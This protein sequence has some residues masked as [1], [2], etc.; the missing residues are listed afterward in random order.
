MNVYLLNAIIIF[1]YFTAFFVIGQILKNN[2]I[3]DIGWGFGF[4]LVAILNAI[5]FGLKTPGQSIVLIM[6]AVWGLR[7]T[8]HILKR[9]WKKT[10]DFRYVNMRKK[11]G[12]KQMLNAFFKVYMIQGLFMFLIS[13]SISIVFAN[14]IS[15]I[16]FLIGG[17]F[18]WLFGFLFEAVGDYQLKNFIKNKKQKGD[19]IKTGLWKYTRHPNYFGESVIWWGIALIAFGSSYSFLSLVSPIVIT[20]LLVKVSG[21]PMLEEK[22]MKNPKFVEYAKVTNKFIPWFPKKKKGE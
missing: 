11:W 8:Y 15:N 14:N 9:N 2:S 20:F 16:Y 1:A 18:V 4:V 6:V 17:I 5:I 13:L 21:V 10:E 3:V 22:M 19:V 7:L 12:N